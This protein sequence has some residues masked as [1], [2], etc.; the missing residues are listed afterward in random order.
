MKKIFLLAFFFV[1]WCVLAPDLFAN[2]SK[3]FQILAPDK[4]RVVVNF[5]PQY[6]ICVYNANG[7]SW[8]GLNAVN[9]VSMTA[10]CLDSAGQGLKDLVIDFG[11]DY[12]ILLYRNGSWSALNRATAKAIVPA[13]INGDGKD[14]LVIDFGSRYGILIYT[15]GVWSVLNSATARSIV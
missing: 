8:S 12:G 4:G 11:L 14:E 6:G 1:A 9:P 13:D 2:N 15:S 3:A 5:G 10:A 7:G